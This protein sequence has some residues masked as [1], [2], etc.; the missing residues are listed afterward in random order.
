MLTKPFG[1]GLHWYATAVRSLLR[2]KESSRHRPPVQAKT[3]KDADRA[4]CKL[5]SRLEEMRPWRS[6]RTQDPSVSAGL[7]EVL[8][9]APAGRADDREHLSSG[10]IR[11]SPV[12]AGT[13]TVVMV[14]LARA[15][16]SF[17]EEH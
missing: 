15:S 14:R 7:A 13:I 2:V 6:S 12:I 8:W 5:E 11:C 4:A 16:T 3:L 1:A 10:R 17:T 9:A